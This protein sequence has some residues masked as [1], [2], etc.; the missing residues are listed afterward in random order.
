MAEGAQPMTRLVLR[1]DNISVPPFDPAAKDL[2]DSKNLL[3][4][5]FVNAFLTLYVGQLQSQT[6]VTFN[7][8]ALS[9]A[10]GATDTATQ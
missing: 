7:Q 6:K 5:Q 8:A 2:A 1:I 3:D 10:L 9:A 4:G